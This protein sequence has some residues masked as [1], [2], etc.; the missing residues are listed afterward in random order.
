MLRR[1]RHDHPSLQLL[2]TWN[3]AVNDSMLA[4]NKRLGYGDRERWIEA[5]LSVG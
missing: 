1:L 2:S 5:E 3:A 4:V